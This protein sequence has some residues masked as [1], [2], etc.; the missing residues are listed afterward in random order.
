M[1]YVQINEGGYAFYMDGDVTPVP[2]TARK[3]ST[4]AHAK[5]FA[6]N[7]SEFKWVAVG[8]DRARLIVVTPAP[9]VEV[10]TDLTSRQFSRVL[11]EIGL[12]DAAI[13]AEIDK[14]ED[15]RE[16]EIAR[17]DFTKATSFK[18]DYPLIDQIA[19]AMGIPPEQVDTLWRFGGSF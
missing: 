1:F 14:I 2:S 18:R 8:E 6:G 4:E 17:V 3:I 12:N 5:F 15:E 10:F 7:Q 19:T 16:R 9:V 13:L 11:I